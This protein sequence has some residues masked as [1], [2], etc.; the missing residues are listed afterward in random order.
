MNKRF[1]LTSF[2]IVALATLNNAIAETHIDPEK[3]AEC[4]LSSAL[5]L[6]IEAYRA[7]Q[8]IEAYQAEKQKTG[9]SFG[10]YAELLKIRMDLVNRMADKAEKDLIKFGNAGRPSA[11]ELLAQLKRKL[12]KEAYDTITDTD[13][14]L[15]RRNQLYIAARDEDFHLKDPYTKLPTTTH[16]SQIKMHDA[17]TKAALAAIK[18][19]YAN[20]IN[21]GI[22]NEHLG[23]ADEFACFENII[24]TIEK[25]I[26]DTITALQTPEPSSFASAFQLYAKTFATN[27]WTKRV[28]CVLVA[29]GICQFVYNR[30]NSSDKSNDSDESDNKENDKK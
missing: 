13:A 22:N 11:I 17:G 15:K 19:N 25:E 8:D 10:N 3:A 1:L 20:K 26:D 24:K 9:Y 18:E 14:N 21:T 23:T 16:D 4:F 7:K 2:T 12:I 6:K 29:C 27:K 30:Y 5:H 28:A